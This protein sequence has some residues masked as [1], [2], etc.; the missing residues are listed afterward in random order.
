MTVLF[1][2]DKKIIEFVDNNPYCIQQLAEMVWN[3]SAPACKDETIEDAFHALIDAQAGLNL[4]LTQTL[5]LTQQNL[6][7]AIVAGEKHSGKPSRWKIPSMHG[8]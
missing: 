6:L 3:R 2:A 8:G 1:I 7:H 5:T 4:A